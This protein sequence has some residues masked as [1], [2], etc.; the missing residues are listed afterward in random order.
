MVT[1]IVQL[2]FHFLSVCLVIFVYARC[3]NAKIKSLLFSF[4]FDSIYK[5]T[6]IFAYRPPTNLV[7][8]SYIERGV[9]KSCSRT[10]IF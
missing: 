6:A 8:C 7:Q 2:K 3:C 9:C 1:I 10:L 5:K 4:W